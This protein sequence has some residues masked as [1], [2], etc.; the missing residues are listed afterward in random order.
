[1]V[2]WMALILS[3][4]YIFI[5]DIGHIYQ[6]FLRILFFITPIFYDVSFLKSK[7]A[8]FIVS[9]HPLAYFM[10]FSRKLIIHGNIFSFKIAFLFLLINCIFIYLGLK[11][12]KIFEPKFAE[13]L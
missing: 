3:F 7:V 1:M 5:R 6:I 4:I 13:Y 11:I 10:D 9:I 12:F 2:L 8:R